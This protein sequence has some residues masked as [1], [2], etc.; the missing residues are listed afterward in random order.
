MRRPMRRPVRDEA[1]RE[2]LHERRLADGE[3][4]RLV[5]VGGQ[6]EE[7]DL[8]PL[9]P[10]PRVGIDPAGR[11]GGK[12]ASGV[13]PYRGLGRG[14]RRHDQLPPVLVRRLLVVADRP[15]PEE[16]LHRIVKIDERVREALAED[17]PP[18]SHGLGVEQVDARQAGRRR[19]AA[20]R[21][22]RR[23]DV[24]RARQRIAGC[25][26]D[27]ARLAEHDRRPEAA[28]V[29]GEFRPWCK[30]RPVGALDPAVVGDV[31]H[32]RVPRE[33]FTIEVFEQVADR[34]VEPLHVAPVA[35]HVEAVSA[36]SVVI[37]Q[38]L[39]RIVR[40]V[41]QHRGVPDEEWPAV[42]AAAAD[43]VVDRLKRL[44]ADRES[45]VAVPLPLRHAL[46]EPAA[47]KVSLPPLAG[48]QAFV[49]AVG[50]EPRQERPFLEVPIHRFAAGDKG[51]PAFRAIARN[52]RI[53]GRIVAN[54]AVLVR[55]PAGDDRG[56]A[57]AAEAAGHVAKPIDET[58]PRKPVEVRRAEVLVPHEAVVAPVLVVGDD[59]DD[60]L[61]C[62]PG[63]GRILGGTQPA[64]ARSPVG[65]QQREPGPLVD[66][67]RAHCLQSHLNVLVGSRPA[68]PCGGRRAS[69]V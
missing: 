4:L 31:D 10:L 17:L 62:G 38:L 45:L 40:I 7:L 11:A 46:S 64:P 69:A 12:L 2:L 37:H 15:P 60:V 42:V 16:T 49:A 25:R 32:K 34:A 44:P 54:N 67:R 47:G 59:E 23:H 5:G 55:Q 63:V 36:G 30:L 22:H 9:P 19:H 53:L 8:P 35:G 56:E 29:G 66:R 51:C 3:V 39:R 27:R 1:L 18:L 20:G 33:P 28:L 43:E 52:P 24:D 61:G 21:Q 68:T 50:Q 57:R 58:L 26:R 13:T 6:I 14:R 41:R 48:L 65:D